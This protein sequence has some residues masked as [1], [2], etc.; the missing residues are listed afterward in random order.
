[1]DPFE[2]YLTI[3]LARFD[4]IDFFR[5]TEI[6]NIPYMKLSWCTL[7]DNRTIKEQR[8]SFLWK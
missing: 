8:I 1:M 3:V 5:A 4:D 2:C 7:K 6:K